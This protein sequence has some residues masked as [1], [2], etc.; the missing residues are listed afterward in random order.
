[1][2]AYGYNEE[3]II[4]CIPSTEEKY[5]G[6]SKENKRTKNKY[7]EI[8]FLDTLTFLDA[9]I[10]TLPSNL[11]K[12]CK[13]MQQLRDIFKNTYNSLRTIVNLV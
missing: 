5:I 13:I 4:S 11:K 8:R 6:C 12:D 7:F 9:S 3:E 1:M 10:A 2:N